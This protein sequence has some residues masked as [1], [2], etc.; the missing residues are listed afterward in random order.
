MNTNRQAQANKNDIDVQQNKAASTTEIP[1]YLPYNVYSNLN[2]LKQK[3]QEDIHPHQLTP[4]ELSPQLKQRKRHSRPLKLSGD[5]D[6]GTS[7]LRKN[8][9]KV[10]KVTNDDVTVTKNNLNDENVEHHHKHH[11]HHHHPN[12]AL[13]ESEPEVE[14][15][16]EIIPQEI[17]NNEL[18]Q[19]TTV[20]QIIEMDESSTTEAA[21]T[22]TT[23]STS[24]AAPAIIERTTLS[25]LKKK[26]EEKAQR[27]ERLKAK[28]ALLTPEERQV[29]FNSLSGNL[30]KLTV[31]FPFN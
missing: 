6:L 1:D 10:K 14:F 23:Q 13:P 25:E 9:Q 7:M 15:K 28:L 24:T 21:T 5:V 30:P 8:R 31:I 12:N 20:E 29:R 3:P 11:H 4:S 19:P 18:E 2:T 26:L 27:R 17:A 22:T 16:A